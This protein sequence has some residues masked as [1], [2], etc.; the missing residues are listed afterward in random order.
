M[1]DNLFVV[2][3]FTLFMGRIASIKFQYHLNFVV[4]NFDEFQN[5]KFANFKNRHAIMLMISLRAVQQSQD[6]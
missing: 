2:L 6:H 1:E 5:F 3:L 4:Q